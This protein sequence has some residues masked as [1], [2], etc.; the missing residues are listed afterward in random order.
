MTR[1]Y[2]IT[3][4]SAALRAITAFCALEPKTFWVLSHLGLDQIIQLLK[5]A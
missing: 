4:V 3:H 2:V 5:S 1:F